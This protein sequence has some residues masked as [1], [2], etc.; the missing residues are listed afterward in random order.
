MHEKQIQGIDGLTQHLSL[1][2]DAAVRLYGTAPDH[3]VGFSICPCS[4]FSIQAEGVPPWGASF[5]RGERQWSKSQAKSS[6]F[7]TFFQIW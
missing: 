5:S 7:K 6:I 3:G 2:Q 1:A 4:G